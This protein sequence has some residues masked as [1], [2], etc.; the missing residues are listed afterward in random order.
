MTGT[1]TQFGRARA[2]LKAS[3]SLLLSPPLAAISRILITHLHG[4]H[5]YGLPGLLCTLSMARPKLSAS[6]ASVPV[7]NET[8]A[9]ETDEPCAERFSESQEFL[10]IVG[11]LGTS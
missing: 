10:E 2:T 11:P 8:E 1:Q 4:D 5:C 7:D 9:D 6:K 3:A